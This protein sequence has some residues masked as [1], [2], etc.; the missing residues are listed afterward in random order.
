MNDD[1]VFLATEV[2]DPFERRGL[3]A[4]EAGGHAAG[5]GAGGTSHTDS[6]IMVSW[7]CIIIDRPWCDWYLSGTPAT[8]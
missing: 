6:T 1:E 4:S 5:T 8:I 3:C 2:T 7:V